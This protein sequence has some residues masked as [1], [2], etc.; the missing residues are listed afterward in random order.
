MQLYSL[1]KLE[2]FIKIKRIGFLLKLVTASK[3]VSSQTPTGGGS[4]GGKTHVAFKTFFRAFISQI[5]NLKESPVK[6]G[7]DE[8]GPK[9]QI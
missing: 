3:N 7:S 8:F 2:G 4:Q 1:F 5:T 6:G 9:A